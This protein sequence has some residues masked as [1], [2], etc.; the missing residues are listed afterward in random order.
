[1][2]RPPPLNPVVAPSKN[3]KNIRKTLFLYIMPPPQKFALPHLKI[4]SDY[5]PGQNN[6][7]RILT[8]L[9]VRDTVIIHLSYTIYLLH[10]IYVAIVDSQKCV[11]TVV[12][13]Y[14][15]STLA[16]AL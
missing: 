12:K 6:D 4:C 8:G 7:P 5:G 14:E 16:N 2:G 13:I 3:I 15:Q 11:P 1:M 9:R 10:I